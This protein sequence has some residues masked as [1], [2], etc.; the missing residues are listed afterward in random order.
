LDDEDVHQRQNLT[1]RQRK[2]LIEN[3]INSPD[4]REAS[5]YEKDSGKTLVNNPLGSDD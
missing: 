4:P 1:D 5:F 2:E 3:I